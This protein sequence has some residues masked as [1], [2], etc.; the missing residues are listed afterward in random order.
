MCVDAGR[1]AG[2]ER[3]Q[4]P[5]TMLGASS[6][7]A[8]AT[9]TSLSLGKLQLTV[10]CVNLGRDIEDAGVRLVI[11]G[12]FGR[13]SPV[14]GAS[15]Q[16]NG[17][18]VGGRLSPNSVDEPHREWLGGGVA[19]VGGGGVQIVLE[20]RVTLLTEGA[21]SE[22]D[23]AVA[24]LDIAGLAHDIV[25]I[26]Y[27]EIGESSMVLLEPLGALCV[28]LTRHLCPEIS[29]LLAELFD[30]RLRLEVLEGAADGRIGKSDGDGAE[31]ARVQFW[32]A[33]HDIEGALR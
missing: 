26:G 12:D 18:V 5:E 8:T 23:G 14:V 2:I 28:R 10:E 11:A 13:Q 29:K 9:L 22:G 16:V 19:D 24:Q 30:L 33:L 17:L 32:V 27:D 25:G 4:G 31:S 3:L 20:D 1:T 6:L 7:E 15:G 21:K